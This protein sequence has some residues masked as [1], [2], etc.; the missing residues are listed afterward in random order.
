[1][2]ALTGPVSSQDNLSSK[3]VR[4]GPSGPAL[5]ERAR[6]LVRAAHGSILAPAFTHAESTA[7]SSSVICVTLPKGIMR[8]ATAC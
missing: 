3:V 4:G 8:E 7:R 1:M 6:M 5:P 2:E